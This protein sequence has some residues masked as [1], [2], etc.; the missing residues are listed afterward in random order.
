MPL[1][2]EQKKLTSI[3]REIYDAYGCDGKYIIDG[4]RLIICQSNAKTDDLKLKYQRLTSILLV[5]GLVA[6][7]SIPVQPIENS[8]PDM[9]DSVAGGGLHGKDLSKADVSI[10]IYCSKSPRNWC[11]C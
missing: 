2:K 11:T 5:N 8:V 9:A 4:D 1:T 10:N 3:A 6:L 7:M